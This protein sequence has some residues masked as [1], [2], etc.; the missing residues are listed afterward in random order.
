MCNVYLPCDT[1]RCAARPDKIRNAQHYPILTGALLSLLAN[2]YVPDLC[3]PAWFCLY[4]QYSV[5]STL[6]SGTE[7][8]ALVKTL[9]DQH[10]N[11]LFIFHACMMS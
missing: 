4:E 10:R 3:P 5:R 7:A 6:L 2:F 9:L 1:A 11:Q 8:P